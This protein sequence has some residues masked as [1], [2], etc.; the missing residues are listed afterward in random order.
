M[1]LNQLI[2]KRNTPAICPRGLQRFI[3]P[4][5]LFV[6]FISTKVYSVLFSN[7]SVLIFLYEIHFPNEVSYLNYLEKDFSFFHSIDFSSLKPI[8][9]FPG[10]H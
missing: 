10:Q 7:S 1:S 4:F 2:L 8:G 9:K 6:N 3:L 5:S